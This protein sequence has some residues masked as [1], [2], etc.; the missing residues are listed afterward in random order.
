MKSKFIY[1]GKITIQ[2]LRNYI[3][4]NGVTEMIRYC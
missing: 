1:I 3:L 2:S 4:D